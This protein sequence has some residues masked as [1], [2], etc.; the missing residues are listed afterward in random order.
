MKLLISPGLR[1]TCGGHSGMWGVPHRL[2]PMAAA[3]RFAAEACIMLS[4][5]HVYTWGLGLS[6]RLGQGDE[7]DRPEPYKHEGL[8]NAQAGAYVR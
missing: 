8:S 4:T 3:I 7:N 6:G 1:R 2:G 5:P